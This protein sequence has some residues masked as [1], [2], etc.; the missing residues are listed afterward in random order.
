ME[1]SSIEKEIRK[2]IEDIN[3]FFPKQLTLSPKQLAELRGTSIQTL[4]R[5]RQRG[6]GIAF[7]ERNNQVEYPVREIAKWLCSTVQT[8]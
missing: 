1:H 6:V 7:K 4:R 8:F 5:E 3:I 2:H